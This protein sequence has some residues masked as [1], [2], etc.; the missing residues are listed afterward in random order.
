MQIRLTRLSNERHL[1]RIVREDGTNEERE[2][3]TR[4]T[5]LHDLVHYALE[6]EAGLA[7]GFWG[8]L[9]SGAHFD[10]LRD[11]AAATIP[12]TLA[13]AESLV[14]P[15][16]AVWQGRLDPEGYV[17]LARRAAPFVDRPFVERVRERVRRLW[18]RWH[19]TP[20][21]ASMELEWPPEREERADA[22]IG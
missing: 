14:G 15:M 3:E 21:H 10:A 20:F 22:R 5:L 7:D 13:L 8:T 16:Q 11:E 4:S 17:E 12:P 9:A 19:G 1:L 6:A 2:L 18:G